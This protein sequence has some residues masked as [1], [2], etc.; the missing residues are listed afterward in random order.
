M[1][2]LLLWWAFPGHASH[3]L[4][5]SIDKTKRVVSCKHKKHTICYPTDELILWPFTLFCLIW[6]VSGPQQK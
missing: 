1:N 2:Y 4:V 3:P 5:I 6:P